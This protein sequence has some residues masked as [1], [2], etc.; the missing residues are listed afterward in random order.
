MTQPQSQQQQQLTSTAPNPI[1]P[2]QLHWRDRIRPDWPLPTIQNVV[3]TVNLECRLDLKVIAEQARNVEYNRH[4][5]H[6]LVQRI[7]DPKTTALVFASGK[8]VITGAKSERLA[9]LAGR[10]HARAIQKCGFRTKFLDFKVQNFVGS[11]GCNFYIRLD[12]IHARYHQFAT[13]E[14]ELFPG[15]VYRLVKPLVVVLIF[16]NGKVVLTGAKTE[17]QLFDAFANIYPILLDFKLD[18][19]PGMEK[20]KKVVRRR[21]G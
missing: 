10:R 18:I 14:P 21:R 7:R 20:A 19:E 11:V 17:D 5:F 1:P 16:A 4:K 8:L 13:Y 15:L 6:A 12:G 3:A 9:H 2:H